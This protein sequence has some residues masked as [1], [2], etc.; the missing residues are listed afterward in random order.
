MNFSN[1]GLGQ[2]VSISLFIVIATVSTLSFL[3]FN[4]SF[5]KSIY[6]DIELE[7]SKLKTNVNVEYINQN[8][9]VLNSN[10]AEYLR[11]FQITNITGDL[12][13]GF[14]EDNIKNYSLDTHLLL[15]FDS[16]SIEGIDIL[17]KSFYSYNGFLRGDINGDNLPIISND[18]I[19][20]QCLEFNGNN[21]SVLIPTGPFLRNVN[22][23]FS[24]SIWVKPY[25]PGTIWERQYDEFD[26]EFR[27]STIY[28][29][30]FQ[31]NLR[32]PVIGFI[33]TGFVPIFEVDWYHIVLVYN[34]DLDTFS[35]YIDS[36]LKTQVN[37]SGFTLFQQSSNNQP[38]GIGSRPSN[39]NINNFGGLVDEM[40]FYKTALTISEINSLYNLRKAVFYDQ[41]ITKG[42]N[43][44]NLDECNLKKGDIVDIFFLLGDNLFEEQ[45]IVR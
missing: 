5:L 24:A 28:P 39:G 32:S 31:A 43:I 3:N 33:Y 7:T 26:L 17:D 41:I 45:L 27:S 36:E 2:I 18:C 37:N 1:K 4:E 38:L 14:N 25:T 8:F 20:N 19:S 30:R 12:V 15:D 40:V 9:L 11:V 35:M 6:P 13:C 23:S 16:S 44:I 10:K 21:N 34:R 42:M 22:S 29:G